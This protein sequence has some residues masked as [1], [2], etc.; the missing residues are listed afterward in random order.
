MTWHSLDYI[1]QDP[2]VKLKLC[3]SEDWERAQNLLQQFEHGEKK[4]KELRAV[5]G[6]SRKKNNIL[7]VVG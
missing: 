6:Q 4:R 1:S 3:L 7:P 5:Q 2:A